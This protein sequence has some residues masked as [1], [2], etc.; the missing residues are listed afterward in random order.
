MEQSTKRLYDSMAALFDKQKM[1]QSDLARL[2]NVPSQTIKNWE[3]RGLPDKIAID[4][5]ER[6]GIPSIW[7]SRGIG[8]NP[9]ENSHKGDDL[10]IA[11]RNVSASMGNGLQPSEF[12]LVVDTM[13]ISRE[14]ARKELPKISA[15]QNLQIISGI[16]DSMSPTYHSGDLLLVDTGDCNIKSDLIYVFSYKDA[17]YVKRIFIDP[18][19]SSVIVKSDNPSASNWQP[20]SIKDLSEFI[21][22]G[23]VI[24]A[25]QGKK[26]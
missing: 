23:R 8:K 24:Y 15:I 22:H 19:S 6:F 12:E 14:W 20:L 1:S 2:F 7:L 13:R 9:L 17:T 18:V 5:E 10:F 3:N 21:V 26:I 4:A 11:I 16:G 25:W